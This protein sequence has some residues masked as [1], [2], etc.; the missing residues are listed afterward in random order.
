M[1]WKDQPDSAGG[2]HLQGPSIARAGLEACDRLHLSAPGNNNNSGNNNDDSSHLL[3]T[4]CTSGSVLSALH[5]LSRGLLE[6]TYGAAL[7]AATTT[8]TTDV[9]NVY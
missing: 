5:T 2:Q 8:T 4:H 9:V 3:S 1:F 7:S 6:T